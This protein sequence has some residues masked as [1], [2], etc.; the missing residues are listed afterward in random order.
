MLPEVIADQIAER[1]LR[2]VGILGLSYKGDLKV[3]VL[4][5]TLRMS[6]RLTERG[7]KVKVNDPYYTPDEIKRLTGTENFPFPQ[8]LTEFDCVVIVAGHRTYKAIPEAKLKS[9]LQNC[10]LVLDNLEEIWRTF[11]L[12]SSGIE[13]H[14]AGDKNWLR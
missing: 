11:N 8:G 6:R 12:H 5:P 7:V 10:K 9:H 3:H 14:V 13:Y 4:S 2:N 1:G